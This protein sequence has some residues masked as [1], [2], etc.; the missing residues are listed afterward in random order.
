[1]YVQS[2]DFLNQPCVHTYCSQKFILFI[3]YQLCS[4]ILN[5]C[6]VLVLVVPCSILLL[7]FNFHRF[8]ESHFFIL[9]Q[10]YLLLLANGR[11][12]ELEHLIQYCPFINDLKKNRFERCIFSI[13]G[14]AHFPQ[15]LNDR[16]NINRQ[17]I[18]RFHDPRHCVKPV[19][20]SETFIM[21]VKQG[22][23]FG[24]FPFIYLFFDG[25]VCFGMI[26]IFFYHK[27]LLD[28]IPRF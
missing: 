16:V 11:S 8:V 19:K 20:G 23:N 22:R 6:L 21:R 10:Y 27:V 15:T 25:L 9:N 13:F 3:H 4:F 7:Q 26:F 5:D 28:A 17:K 24:E 2:Q 14:N 18:I 12:Q 1:M